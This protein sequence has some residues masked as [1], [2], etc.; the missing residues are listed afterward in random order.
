M[1]RLFLYFP[2]LLRALLFRAAPREE[3][4]LLPGFPDRPLPVLT[5]PLPLRPLFETYH[6][7]R[8]IRSTV[9]LKRTYATGIHIMITKMIFKNVITR[10]TPF[11]DV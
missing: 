7:N 11:E 10:I 5:L 8:S 1:Y 2:A 9:S 4:F 3:A 6:E